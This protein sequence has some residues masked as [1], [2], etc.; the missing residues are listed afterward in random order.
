[1]CRQK[2]KVAERCRRYEVLEV[3]DAVVIK[4]SAQLSPGAFQ[5]AANSGTPTH[6]QNCRVAMRLSQ[7]VLA[8][9]QLGITQRPILWA[10]NSGCS[11]KFDFGSMTPGI[12][13]FPLGNLTFSNSAHSCA[14]RGLAASNE[15]ACGLARNTISTMSARRIYCRQSSR[16]Q[17]TA[18]ALLGSILV[19]RVG[20]FAVSS[21]CSSRRA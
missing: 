14:Y 12:S 3:Y 6:F 15:M 1:V 17:S 9:D 5:V 19:A 20:G 10:I 16:R 13:T 8:A 21:S 11:M 18:F 2:P 7:G 4:P